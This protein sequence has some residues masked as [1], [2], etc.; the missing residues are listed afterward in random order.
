MENLTEVPSR[1]LELIV[2]EKEERRVLADLE[3]RSSEYYLNTK[4]F[5]STELIDKLSGM[6]KEKLLWCCVD[7]I[8]IHDC[9]SIYCNL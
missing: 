3:L 9:D 7:L 4:D 2:K 6:G 1:N 5:T 8:D